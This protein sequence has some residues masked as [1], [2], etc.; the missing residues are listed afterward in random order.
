MPFNVICPMCRENYHETTDSF[1]LFHYLN[2]LDAN[3]GMLKL[4]DEYKSYGWDEPPPD[5][6]GG[7]GL[8]ECPGCGAMLAP[9]GHFIVRLQEQPI[10]SEVKEKQPQ[11]KEKVARVYICEICGEEFD[12]PIK[13]AAHMRKHKKKEKENA[14]RR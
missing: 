13:K 11:T 8:L 14:E 1:K 4:K 9:S 7:Y 6:T 10:E 5:P 12:M 2:L 3:A